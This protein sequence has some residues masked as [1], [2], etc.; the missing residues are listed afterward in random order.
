MRFKTQFDPHDRVHCN[1]GDPEKVLYG[2]AYD[3]AGRIVLEEKGRENLYDF[4]QSHADSVD[5]HVLLAR[6]RNGE[7]DAL[8]KVQGMYGDFTELPTTYAEMLNVVQRGEDYFNSLPV[9]TRAKFDHSFSQFLAS[10]DNPDFLT[11]MGITQDKKESA[12]ESAVEP[13]KEVVKE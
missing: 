9:E 7:V 1:K 12:V 8:S 11:L 10:M 3:A 4:I 13:V 5:I 2:A 6:Y